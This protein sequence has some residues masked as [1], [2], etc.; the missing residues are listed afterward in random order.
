VNWCVSKLQSARAIFKTLRHLGVHN[1]CLSI[2][3]HMISVVTASVSLIA[4]CKHF[5]AVDPEEFSLS[6]TVGCLQ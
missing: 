5:S 1:I 3:M 2:I 6:F 4:H